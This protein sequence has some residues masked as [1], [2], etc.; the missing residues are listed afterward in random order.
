MLSTDDAV[1]TDAN[2]VCTRAT[3]GDPTSACVAP[4]PNEVGDYIGAQMVAQ[5]LAD[6]RLT[7]TIAWPAPAPIVY[8]TAL[9]A[10]Q[11]NAKAS[12]TGVASVAGTFTYTPEA[13]AFLPAGVRTLQVVFTPADATKFSSQTMTTQITVNRA[14]RKS[15]V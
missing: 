12:A 1:E 3:P 9:G 13:G 11:Q 14:D 4:G 8:G 15:V 6:N 2:R 7:P 10:A 5:N